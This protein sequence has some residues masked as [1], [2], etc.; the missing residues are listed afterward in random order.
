MY[1]ECTCMNI[2]MCMYP[3]DTYV[4]VSYECKLM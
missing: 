1:I 2:R 3:K 4:C